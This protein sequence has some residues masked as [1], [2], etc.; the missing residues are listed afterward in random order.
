MARRFLREEEEARYA[1]QE[2][3]L[4]AFRALDRFDQGSR[5]STWLHRIVIN[6]CLMPL[7]TRRR[8]P[9]E[10][11][12]DFLPQFQSDDHQVRHPTPE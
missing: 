4:S 9:E 5:L 3:F 12:E 2:G 8:K 1:V 6:A 7:R 11:I 10:P